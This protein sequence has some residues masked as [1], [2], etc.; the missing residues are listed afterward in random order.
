MA[1]TVPYAVWAV[2]IVTGASL[3]AI[4]LFGVRSLIQGKINPMT[5]VLT[6]I[7]I[8]LMG[9]LGL[10]MGDWS[11][12]AILA[13]LIALALTSAVLLLSGIKGLFG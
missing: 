12:A 13:S 10:V 3:L 9:I 1:A 11:H 4:A 5:I 8:V 6:A 7:P 2:I